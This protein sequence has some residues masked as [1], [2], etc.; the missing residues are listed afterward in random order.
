MKKTLALVMG[1]ILIGMLNADTPTAPDFRMPTFAEPYYRIH[2]P[3]E[4]KADRVIINGL[5]LNGGN[6]GQF[7]LFKEGKNISA[8]TALDR[9]V[10]DIVID[11]AWSSRRTYEIVL[12]YQQ[13]ASGQPDKLELRGTS[14]RRGGIP[15]GR[16]G[17]Y[18][19]YKVE[20]EAGIGRTQ[21]PVT[22]TLTA[23]RSDIQDGNFVIYDGNRSIPYEIMEKGESVPPEKVASSHPVTQTYKIFLPLDATPREKKWLLV[24][25]GENPAPRVG[26]ISVTGEGLGKTIRTAKFVLELSPQ[27]GQ[28]NTIESLEAGVKLYNKAGVIHWNPDVFVAGIAWDHSFDWNPPLAF[29]EKVGDNYYLNVRKGPMPR[30]RDVDLEVKYT[31]EAA[32]PYFISETRL[33]F[34]KDLGVIA[35]RN[36]EMVL[37]KELFDSL[38]YRDKHQKNIKRP[39]QEEEGFPFGLVHVAP[40]DLDWVGLINTKVNYGFFCLRLNASNGNFELPGEFFHRAGTYF[41]APSDGNYV[42]WVRPLIYTWA[43]FA[44]NNLL[45]FVPKGSFFYEKNAYGIWRLGKNWPQNLDR[46]LTRL[47]NPLRVF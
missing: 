1:L 25:K 46:L 23:A 30:I 8:T 15:G 7:L 27:S 47:R 10:Y 44:T 16:E 5:S 4:V 45:T 3:F 6:L 9:G 42:Y 41:Y 34:E 21:E 32:A 31:V 37:F 26:K 22:L 13:E 33:Q 11:Y 28:I 29:E 39:L 36:D 19:I 40:E 12:L 2:F 18:R 14:P 35:V 20:E 38:V 17:F 24:L 43:D